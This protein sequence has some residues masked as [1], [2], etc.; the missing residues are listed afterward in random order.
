ML[1]QKL[2]QINEVLDNLITLTQE[3]LE[4]IKIANHDAV[5]ANMTKK[6][7][8]AML[9]KQIKSEID[10]I[11]VARNKPIEEI[12]TK[13]E[14]ALFEEFKV[15]L[16]KFNDIHKHFAKIA[17]SVANFYNTLMQ[18]INDTQTIDYS[19]KAQYFNSHLALKA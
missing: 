9:F 11:L 1:I 13:E 10:S 5:F 4:N 17:L 15:K 19:G 18:K 8:L 6:E 16:N 12:F 7:E 3:D 14:E 2:Q